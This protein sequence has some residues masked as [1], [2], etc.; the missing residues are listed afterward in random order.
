MM[1]ASPSGVK[2]KR[3]ATARRMVRVAVRQRAFNRV[4][5]GVARRLPTRERLVYRG[6]SPVGRVR[7]P[8]SDGRRL[9]LW[10]NGDDSVAHWLYWEGF[11]GYDPDTLPIF[12]ALARRASVTLDVGAHT[13]VYGLIAAIE[14]PQSRVLAFEPVPAVFSRLRRHALLNKTANMLCIRAAVGSEAGTSPIYFEADQRGTNNRQD[15]SL[16]PWMRSQPWCAEIVPVVRLDDFLPTAGVDRV[17]LAKIDVERFEP[18]VI[19]GMSEVIAR[20]RPHLVCE[21]FPPEW[22]RPRAQERIESVLLPHG[23]NF[24][25]LTE[26]GPVLRDRIVGVADHLNWLFTMLDA[27]QL[28]AL[29]PARYS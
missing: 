29:E 5:L 12:R 14:S 27:E 22:S 11:E 13:G 21:V 4:V 8:L 28:A 19:E 16:F 24:F 7:V 20:D 25:H 3:H 1:A 18:E 23:Y 26:N 10:S 6:F 17:D 15:A 2:A 9:L